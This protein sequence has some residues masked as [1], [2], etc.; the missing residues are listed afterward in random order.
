[1]A[2]NLAIIQWTKQHSISNFV[3]T[4]GQ[5]MLKF[6]NIAEYVVKNVPEA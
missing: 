6:I 4:V 2:V 1:M 5:N 3:P